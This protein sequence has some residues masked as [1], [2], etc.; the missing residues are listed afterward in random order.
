MNAVKALVAYALQTGL[1]EAGEETWAQNVILE[2]IQA[3]DLPEL[4]VEEKASLPV[5]LDVLTDY[6]LP[7]ATIV[8]R[9]D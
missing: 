1:I 4:E 8:Y 9:E 3:D 2:T 7:G 5:I 6:A